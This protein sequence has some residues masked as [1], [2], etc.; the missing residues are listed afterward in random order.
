MEASEWKVLI[1]AGIEFRKKYSDIAEW[2]T[3]R[4]WT[5]CNFN[6]Q[7][8]SVRNL[9]FSV[10]RAVVPSIYYRNPYIN[11][12]PTRP[13]NSPFAS[14]FETIDNWLVGRTGLKNAIKRACMETFVTGIGPLQSGYQSGRYGID[15]NLDAELYRQIAALS[16]GKDIK[17]SSYDEYRKAEMPWQS[18]V[19]AEEIVFPACTSRISNC[20]WFARF[21]IRSMEDMKNDPVFKVTDADSKH[22]LDVFA[23]SSGKKRAY[24]DVD[25]VVMYYEIHDQQ[26]G[27]ISAICDDHYILE[28]TLDV[29]QTDELSLDVLIFNNDSEWIYGIPDVKVLKPAQEELNDCKSQ[30]KK[31]RQI[32]LL[33]FLYNSNKINKKELD[34]MLAGEVGPAIDVDGDPETAVAIL[35]PHIPPDLI[36]YMA[37]IDQEVKM[38]LRIGS[39][40]M[41]QYD[42][43]SRRTATEAEIVQESFEGGVGDR[44]D[45]VADV[46]TR[47]YNKHNRR[48]M[49]HWKS[50]QVMQIVGVDGMV[51]WVAIKPSNISGDYEIKVD[52][53]SMAKES[54]QMKRAEIVQLLQ[55]LSKFPQVDPTYFIRELTKQF[56]WTDSKQIL[57]QA[58]ETMGQ[59][60]DMGQFAK[61]QNNL[62]T[63]P[64]AYKKRVEGY[65]NY[66]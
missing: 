51:Y 50:E 4:E 62:R 23:P 2:S 29:D 52:V 34:K 63:N 36:A 30:A 8:M 57:P 3:Y 59:P 43:G 61:Q 14:M 16:A 35:Q 19:D 53:E 65:S 13:E 21:V 17:K 18:S 28:P 9:V 11:I 5:R 55:G 24:A 15:R 10:A 32:A 31:H 22:A 49:K 56:N 42:R 46:I 40:Q 41:G 44:R 6:K 7:D 54:K 25:S 64:E 66:A 39:N 1:D 48:I 37:R 58:P 33:K 38:D 27:E 20:R 26:T 60:M 45:A 12:S 47:I